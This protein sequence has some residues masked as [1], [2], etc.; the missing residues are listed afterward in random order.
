[1]K[2]NRFIITCALAVPA[3]CAFS[4]PARAAVTVDNPLLPSL[5]GGAGPG[6]SIDVPS[7]LPTGYLSP[8]DVH[9][10]FSG[11]GLTAILTKVEHLPFA[12]ESRVPG[13]GGSQIE[14]F[15]STLDALVSI[16]GGP[17]NVPIHLEGPTTTRVDYGGGGPFGTF[18]TEMLSLSLTGTSPLG[19][20]MIRESPTLQSTG[21]TQ[22][23]TAPGGL[24]HIDS[25]FDVFTDLSLDGGATWIPNSEGSGSTHVSLQ[26]VPEPGTLLWGAAMGLVAGFRRV[27]A[28]RA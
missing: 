11:P 9:A 10:M 26:P 24:F 16:V 8:A 12:L 21:L 20:I 15:H 19:P 18:S 4:I 14:T 25:F 2:L 28:R 23:Q 27:R 7:G 22:V 17:Q 3:V 13:P 6:S 1:M 5:Q